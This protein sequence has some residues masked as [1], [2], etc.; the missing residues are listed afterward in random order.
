[1]VCWHS[2]FLVKHLQG[3]G[4]FQDGG[5]RANNPLT[6]A[7][8]ES[9]II[10][11]AAGRADLIISIGTGFVPEPPELKDF[12]FRG[13][14]RDGFIPRLIRALLFGPAM[15]GQQAWRDA[16][17]N[18]PSDEQEDIFRLDQSLTGTLPELDNVDRME[19]LSDLPYVI[20]DELVR[21]VLA[22]SFFFELDEVP[23]ESHGVYHC[24]GSILCVEREPRHMVAEILT[25]FPGAQ[26]ALV[27]G[28]YL[29]PVGDD[30]G[31][32]VCGYYRKRVSFQVPSLDE[33][34]SLVIDSQRGCRRIG[35]FPVSMSVILEKQQADAAFGRPDH[36]VGRWPPVR[37]CSCSIGCKRRS[38]ACVDFK[39]PPPEHKKRRL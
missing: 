6:T 14:L 3:F 2:Y 21:A 30:D 16:L 32:R 26:F 4:T 11:P 24:Q 18:I 31:C 39:E 9:A 28:S 10:W 5:V 12:P 38:A 20:P 35:G 19:E 37:I 25:E 7:R 1:V 13:I 36:R 29:G 33:N 8:R 23:I 17:D 22:T 15:D 27:G 34:L